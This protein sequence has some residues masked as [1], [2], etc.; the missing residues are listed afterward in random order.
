MNTILYIATT[1]IAFFCLISILAFILS[2][3]FSPRFRYLCCNCCLGY[4]PAVQR[5]SLLQEGK[6]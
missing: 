3:R 2:Y 1:S 4:A 6:I 5:E